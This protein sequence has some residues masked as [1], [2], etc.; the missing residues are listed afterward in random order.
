ME[1][2][3]FFGGKIPVSCRSS[4][5]AEFWGIV[6]A[7]RA[8]MER[9]APLTPSAVVLQ[10]DNIHALAWVGL[11]HMN[12]RPVGAKHETHPIGP[13]PARAPKSMKWAVQ[14][15]RA[16]SPD[17]AIWLKYVKGHSKDRTVRSWVN[18]GCDRL[19]A[20]YMTRKRGSVRA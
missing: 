2:G 11:F 20:E 3:A 19:A 10:C 5:D 18:E 9:I 17:V 6:L 4:N 15:L 14:A 8:A 7:L 12:A 1:K 13:P 16:M